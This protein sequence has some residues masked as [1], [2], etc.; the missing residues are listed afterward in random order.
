MAARGAIPNSG[1]A[2]YFSFPPLTS[3]LPLLSA[4]AT[5][6]PWARDLCL[7][8]ILAPSVRE[9]LLF[10]IRGRFAMQELEMY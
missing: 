5:T 8:V 9:N 1:R 4:R 3:S 7:C 10:D 6:N 2:G